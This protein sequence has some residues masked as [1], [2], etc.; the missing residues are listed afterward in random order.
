[1]LSKNTVLII[2]DDLLNRTL[3]SKLLSDSYRTIE[4][5]DGAAGLE[6]LE[7]RSREIACVLL[8]LIMPVMDGYEFLRRIRIDPR[9]ANI[10]VLVISS[11][12]DRDGE[13]RCFEL[14][15]WDFIRKP[16]NEVTVKLRISSIINRSQLNLLE[17][18]EFV[19]EHDQLTGLYNRAKFF[20]ETRRMI[21]NNPDTEFV[22][23]HFDIERFHLINDFF[24]EEEGNRLLKYVASALVK[25]AK[26]IRIGTYG[27]IES[28]VFSFCIPNGDINLEWLAKEA[29]RR[30]TEYNY[31]YY[32]EP[33]FGVY[34]ITDPSLSIETIYGRASMASKKCKNK[35]MDYIEY[36]D[37]DMTDHYLMEQRIIN[38]MQG[39][40]DNEEFVVYFQ[41]KYFLRAGMPNGAEALVRWNH[42]KNGLMFPGQ[43][44]PV[45]ERNGFIGKLDYYMWDKVCQYL[46]RWIDEGL[47]PDPVSVN[48]SR[49]NMYNPHL[50]DIISD[51]VK[52]YDIPPALFN[53]E[54]TESA[55]MDNPN[56]MKNTI[57]ALKKRGFV[58][59][60]DDFG[61]GYSSLN[62]LKDIDVDI[63]KIDTK[64]MPKG[65]G[66]SRSERILSSVI[67]MAGWLDLPVVVEGVETTEQRDFL[68]SIGAEYAQGFL[69]ARPMP[70][71]E[72]EKIVRAVGTGD[73][74]LFKNDPKTEKLDSIW[75]A[76]PNAEQIFK[77]IMQPIAIYEYA[78]GVCTPLR[79]NKAF[80]ELFGFEAAI[81]SANGKPGKHMP[82]EEKDRVKAA[83]ETAVKEQSTTQCEYQWY[84]ENQAMLWIHVNFQYIKSVSGSHVLFAT[85]SNVTE[86]KRLECEL[87]N[88]KRSN[89]KK[90]RN[91][92]LIADDSVV[93]RTIL[94]NI[95]EAQY[96][97]LQADNGKKALD[98]LR[99]NRDDVA[100]ILL[101][102]VMPV[103]DGRTFLLT[104]NS[105]PDIANIP[106]VVISDEGRKEE[107]IDA[108]KLGANDYVTKPFIPELLL[109]RV[110]NAAESEASS[111]DHKDEQI[112]GDK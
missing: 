77:N 55:Y 85:F 46:R 81:E 82:A 49:A 60:M 64:F 47:R 83:L 62:T 73:E 23:V 103:M 51:L 12:E 11:D 3:L 97:V 42:P 39:A 52:K 21:D 32:I 29:K 67:R 92:V 99:A 104:K 96:T 91:K 56:Q 14:G 75:S 2:D 44:I 90:Q 50:V 37:Q 86:S 59:M 66:D 18:L 63:L 53:L 40:L 48:V 112:F 106:V 54:I 7:N 38:E 36:Y 16:F 35:Y 4:A 24:G 25:G 101:D 20:A 84:P 28:D 34:V 31:N 79:F 72:Y 58:I 76:S 6:V 111:P 69:F 1:M 95:F 89:T 80:I 98:L 71:E 109:R 78:E 5:G 15:A 17:Q 107:Q 19:A 100:V 68:E 9:F 45:F 10:P 8:D 93:S 13:K 43:F 57:C 41:P 102:M 94:N 108:L 30:L 22:F 88:F 61:S 26:T 74:S 33:T 70:C 87:L 110:R 27:K 105:E 65:D